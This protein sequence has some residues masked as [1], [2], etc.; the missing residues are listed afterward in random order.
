M[1]AVI[2]SKTATRMQD[3][4]TQNPMMNTFVGGLYLSLLWPSMCLKL[5]ILT[6]ANQDF[7]VMD[8]TNVMKLQ[9]LAAMLSTIVVDLQDVSSIP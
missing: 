8:I 5:I 1:L 3:V 7:L 9:R 6:D 4:C 2:F